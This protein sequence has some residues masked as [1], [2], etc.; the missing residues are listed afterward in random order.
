MTIIHVAL[1]T[2]QPVSYTT[3]RT[4]EET[5]LMTMLATP[6]STVRVRNGEVPVGLYI[7]GAWL[8]A[9]RTF[10]VMNPA[11]GATI[12]EVADG[13]V[14]QAVAALDAAVA[15]QG[16]WRDV[17]PRE[18]AD[19]FHRAHRLL[20][21]RAEQIIET[22]TL[23]SGKPL[24]EARGEFQ[25]SV[26]FFLWYAEQIAHLHGTYAH[27]SRGA[28]RIV[29]THQPVGPCLL[30]TP[31]NF[32]LLMIARKAG[33]ALAAG[34]P[35]VVK[36]A[37]ETPLTCALFVEVLHDAG[38][39]AGVVNLVHTTSSSKVS[40]TL[41][42][43]ARLR[44]VSF[45]G[46][47]GVGSTLLSQAAPNITNASMELGGDGPFLVLEDADLD[48]AAEQAI[49]CKFR[50][51][52]QACVAANRIIVA[53]GVAD[54]F[55]RK[56][57]ALTES[58]KVGDGFDPSTEVGPI[59]SAQQRDTVKELVDR[60]AG[61]DATLL[62]G[63]HEIQGGGYF[64]EPTVF[65]VNDRDNDLCHQELFAPIATIYTVDSVAEAVDVA[66]D[67]TYG[68]AAYVFTRDLSRAI[69]VS[70]RLDFGMVGV[71][72]GIMADPAAAFGGIKASGLGREGGH[73][74]IYEFLE[75]KYLAI[76]VDE[77]EVA[78]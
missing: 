67:T 61:I 44:K 53:R 48:L 34:C 39:P 19:L 49:V 7:D 59:I 21:E 12:A 37:K 66:N 17:L 4:F 41:M 1:P 72:R 30:I 55:T 70:E 52:G 76:T 25:L 64:F 9:S 24:S 14:A 22:M 36:S 73:D 45:T 77:T 18:R 75:P 71:N 60:F 54:E 63:G 40:E 10:P 65:S 46:S 15:V 5:L 31:W 43:D 8:P 42:A 74:A 16:S 50:N 69:A 35:V 62:A 2:K 27:G 26:D 6:P 68:L 47:T 56:F 13:T 23:E 38:F 33:A 3:H 32:P 51:A 29:T 57:V 11:S 28:Y 20:V 58:L 78:L